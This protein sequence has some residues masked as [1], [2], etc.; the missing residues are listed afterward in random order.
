MAEALAD[1]E[2]LTVE[3]DG[4]IADRA[5]AIE[6]KHGEEAAQVYFRVASS[7]SPPLLHHVE[8]WL[9]EASYPPR[10][11][12]QHRGTL[13]EL[14]RWCEK[15]ATGPLA[16]ARADKFDHL[17]PKRRRIRWM[18]LRHRLHLLLKWKGVHRTGSTP[19]ATIAITSTGPLKET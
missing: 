10:S 12:V 16:S 2:V 1:R 4:E 13:K 14:E 9:S 19:L 3:G 8:Q 7:H 17:A 5:Y 15:T 11:Q 6:D 18:T